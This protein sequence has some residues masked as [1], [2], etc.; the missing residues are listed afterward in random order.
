MAAGGTTVGSLNVEL[1]LSSASFEQGLKGAGAQLQAFAANSNVASQT[2]A[3]NSKVD[4]AAG[5]NMFRQFT[6]I[7]VQFSQKGV[8]PF[9][10]LSQQLP[11]MADALIVAKQSGA[12]FGQVM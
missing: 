10:V 6:D 12:S 4:Q 1:G 2:V 7:G 9:T 3:N 11:Q 8:S 5:L